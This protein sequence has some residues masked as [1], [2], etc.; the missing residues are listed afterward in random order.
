[1]PH[2]ADDA[3]F[4]KRN[5]SV[6]VTGHQSNYIDIHQISDSIVRRLPSIQLE[7]Q[8]DRQTR[9]TLS[10]SQ[11][12]AAPNN[13][14]Y[15]NLTDET[16]RDEKLDMS[17]DAENA[18]L[19]KSGMGVEVANHYIKICIKRPPPLF[20]AHLNRNVTSLR[21]VSSYTITNQPAYTYGQYMAVDDVVRRAIHLHVQDPASAGLGYHAYLNQEMG[22]ETPFGDLLLAVF[23]QINRLNVS[24]FTPAL[25]FSKVAFYLTPEKLKE[26]W[27]IP[28][29]FIIVTGTSMVVGRVLGWTFGLRKSQR[30]FVMAAAMFMNSNALPI[31]LMRS[32]VVSVPDLAWG[33]DDNKNAM[34]GRAL[35]YLTMYSTLGMVVRY[36]YGVSLLSRADTVLAPATTISSTTTPSTSV[37]G[38]DTDTDRGGER[39]P[40]LVDFTDEGEDSEHDLRT[41]A[42]SSTLVHSSASMKR[43]AGQFTES[44]TSSA[45]SSPRVASSGVPGAAASAPSTGACRSG[46]SPQTQHESGP[47]HQHGT[48]AGAGAGTGA[49]GRPPRPPA[50]RNTTFYNSFPN[51]PNESRADL[52]AWGAGASAPAGAGAGAGAAGSARGVG[53]VGARDAETSGSEHEDE[54]EDEDEVARNRNRPSDLEHGAH[55]HP[56]APHSPSAPST[57]RAALRPLHTHV[58]HPLRT[59]LLSVHAFLTV[60]LYAAALSLA[61]ALTPPLQHALE[62]NAA[63]RPVNGAVGMCGKCAV[64]ITLVVLGGYFWGGEEGKDADNK[65]WDKKKKG[66]KKSDRRGYMQRVKDLLHIGAHSNTRQGRSGKGDEPGRKPGE[67]K[68]VLLAIAAR[69]L[70]TPLMLAPLMVFATK[71]DWHAVFE[72]PIFVVVNTLLLCS[73]PALTLAQ[74]TSAGASGGAFERLISRTIFWSYCVLTPVVMLGSVLGG[75]WLAKL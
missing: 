55:P 58:L 56:H 32:L 20:V 15:A 45:P 30:S 46:K 12:S 33:S 3:P 71:S 23:N 67:T 31:A 72:D 13:G 41:H 62:H 48:G 18:K 66:G 73:P 42:S 2:A 69:M 60:P 21:F 7:P 29:W 26:L 10:R 8:T 38:L 17:R 16:R 19:E 44:P 51:S 28:I 65:D 4:E 61:V 53:G 35:T 59:L 5:G 6:P 52:P 75:L 39:T 24:L 22:G 11:V 37:L 50:R 34:L 57:L 49:N 70:L 47:G 63:L 1:M 40:L 9:Q 43:A 36:S 14:N 27:V 25:L 64:P 68:T 74:I 54:D